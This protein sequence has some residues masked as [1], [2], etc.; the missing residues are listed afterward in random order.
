MLWIQTEPYRFSNDSYD[1][2][3]SNYNSGFAQTF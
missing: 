2:Q 1:Q 3:N